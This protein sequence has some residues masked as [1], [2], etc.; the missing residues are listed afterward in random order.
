MSLILILLKNWRESLIALMAVV[1]IVLF[2]H[3]KHEANR[4]DQ[5]EQGRDAAI[6]L[7]NEQ[8]STKYKNKQGD[9]V[10]VTKVISIPQSQVDELLKQNSLK[11]LSKLEGIKKNGSN[12][13][14]GWTMSAD[15]D[16]SEVPE[17]AVKI[18]C[19]DS[20]KAR[21]FE[22]HDKY[23][24]IHAI[25]L[26]TPTVEIHDKYYGSIELKRIKHWFWKGLI[27]LGWGN[28]WEPVSEITNSNKLIKI[29]SVQ[30]FVIKR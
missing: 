19:K 24:Y 3:G 7:S 11:W 23:N 17:R 8:T 20:I 12:L 22:L 5:A 6:Q 2:F 13:S 14:S 4:A 21:L 26:D 15:F 1:I 9:S 30:V 18:P 16:L 27:H 10:V 28:T 25:V 29:D